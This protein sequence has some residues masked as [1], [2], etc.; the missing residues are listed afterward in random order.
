MK[1]VLLLVVVLFLVAC[2]PQMACQNACNEAP[3]SEN[4]PF[5]YEEMV[6]N[7]FLLASGCYYGAIGQKAPGTPEGWIHIDEGTQRNSWCP[8]TKENIEKCDCK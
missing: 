2:S 5:T 6:E 1:Y 4:V 7:N 3:A 8:R